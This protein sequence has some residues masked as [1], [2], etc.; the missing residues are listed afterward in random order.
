MSALVN[1]KNLKI[2]D[3]SE[4][5][6]AKRIS[7]WDEVFDA[8]KPGKALILEGEEAKP[9][10][11][12]QALSSRQKKGLYLNYKITQ[13]SSSGSKKENKRIDKSIITSL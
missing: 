7:V 11:I 1:L 10:T 3:A 5:P 9:A 13:R 4:V 12:R 6:S 8:I 2:I